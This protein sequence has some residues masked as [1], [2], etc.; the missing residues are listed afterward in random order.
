M[1]HRNMD[2]DAGPA[3]ASVRSLPTPP[4]QTPRL[5]SARNLT[6]SDPV[7]IFEPASLEINEDAPLG[8]GGF[9]RV[10]S[11]S[12]A[13]VP[14][15]VKRFS[16]EGAGDVVVLNRIERE[17]QI[18]QRVRDPRVIAV[19]GWM[20][21]TVGSSASHGPGDRPRLMVNIVMEL[22]PEGS[23]ERLLHGG[24]GAPAAT[25][26]SF[27]MCARLQLLWQVASTLARLHSGTLRVTSD[28]GAGTKLSI[29]VHGDLKPANILL[30]A[31]RIPKL[32]DFGMA[33]V[34]ETATKDTLVGAQRGCGTPEYICPSLLPTTEGG[35]W[36]A[37]LPA[38]DVFALGVV[39]WEVLTGKRPYFEYKRQLA[40][41]VEQRQ[42][43]AH[44]WRRRL[45]DDVK[46][47]GLRPSEE[48][49]AAGTQ[50]QAPP[51][52][53][54]A[55]KRLMTACWA[56]PETGAAAGRPSAAQVAVELHNMLL[57][58]RQAVQQGRA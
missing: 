35:E 38:T 39:I 16:V 6:L 9:A 43:T 27:P 42:L 1:A 57:A 51:A 10:F 19:Y 33:S 55:L 32:S 12:L 36:H 46:D 40:L 20:P 54:S 30:G 29:V 21:Q 41:L 4:P 5:N 31:G 11:A 8:V 7:D 44:A 28:A 18:Q 34:R 58:C 25:Y 45:L 24:G 37:Y 52:V 48:E 49:F 14:V 56:W 23:L 15:A 13:G 17:V 50:G 22:A 3:A 26:A 47:R 53:I 2:V